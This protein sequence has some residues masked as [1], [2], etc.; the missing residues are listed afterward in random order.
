MSSTLHYAVK[1][2]DGKITQEQGK[3]DAKRDQ[4]AYGGLIVR[5]KGEGEYK[6]WKPHHIFLWVF[7]AVQ[8]IFIAWIITAIA[9]AHD[10]PTA[11]QIA[12]FCGNNQ[13]QG[14]FTS[15]NDCVVHG[16]NGLRAA[17]EVG[18]TI[19]VGLVIGVWLG[20][21]FLLGLTYGIYRLA[22]R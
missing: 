17:G 16:A 21:D 18:T 19:G 8:A 11:T 3:K 1:D 22:K 9:G 13:W 7:L 4:K 14:V 6:P 5:S 10:A 20:V 15:Y 2:R 12:Q